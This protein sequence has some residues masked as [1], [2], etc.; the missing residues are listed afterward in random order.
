LFC[1][2]LEGEDYSLVDDRIGLVFVDEVMWG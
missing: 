1:E 2:L